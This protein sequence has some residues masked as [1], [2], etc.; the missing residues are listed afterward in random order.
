MNNK[1]GLFQ[2]LK[3][4]SVLS[5]LGI[6]LCVVVAFFIFCGLSFDKHFDTHPYGIMTGILLGFPIGVYSIY[7]KIRDN[8]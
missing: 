1:E 2:A 7:L 4:F 6:Y 3:A 5:G 8:L